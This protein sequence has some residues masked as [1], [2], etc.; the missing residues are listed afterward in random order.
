[1]IKDLA[2]CQGLTHTFVTQL[3]H[4]LT[5]SGRLCGLPSTSVRA[6]PCIL[7]WRGRRSAQI[8]VLTE[9]AQRRLLIVREP[10]HVLLLPGPHCETESAI[11]DL[12]WR[13]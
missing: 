3:T 9:V 12:V 13:R 11:G 2:C 7:R 1:V 8:Q 5:Q 4:S 6:S 10:R